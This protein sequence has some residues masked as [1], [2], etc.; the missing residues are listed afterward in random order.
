MCVSVHAYVCSG[1]KRKY[2]IL[3]RKVLPV[4]SNSFHVYNTQ[5]SLKCSPYTITPLS[6]KA[7]LVALAI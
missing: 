6:P 4:A 1:E 5:N 3:N 2:K 7:V